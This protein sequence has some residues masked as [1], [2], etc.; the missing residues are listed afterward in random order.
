MSITITTGGITMTGAGVTFT[1][2]PP[3][4]AT[5]GWFGGGYTPSTVSTVSRI[6]FATDTATAS[7]RGSLSLARRA[8][9]ATGNT[10]D[11]WF[12]AGYTGLSPTAW[13]SLV[14]R[15]TYSTD[16]ATATVR[17]PMNLAIYGQG[18]IGTTEYGWFT[19]GYINAT[20]SANAPRSYVNRITY[21]TDTDTSSGRGPL[22]VSQ[23][24]AFNVTDST[25]YGWVAG[26]FVVATT[27][28]TVSRIIYATDTA[29][30]TTRGPLNGSFGQASG[31]ASSTNSYGWAVSGGFGT[32]SN[33][34]T[35]STIQR[36]TFATDTAT[37]SV[38]G[39]LPTYGYGSSGVGD[40]TYGWYGGFTGPFRSTV[41]RLTYATDTASATARGPLYASQ[42]S[43][44]ATSGIQ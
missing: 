23:S 30:A 39:N 15:I 9:A 21:A 8:L 41:Q 4:E 25:T 5:A 14:D 44:G 26:G 37:A 19:G 2:S 10:T 34:P 12:S 3:S 29:T 13:T 6:T 24:G 7:V 1:A 43:T 18:A 38:R 32:G 22:A 31:G 27:I 28:S 11:G 40:T 42:A 36:I 16:T 20:P 33:T 17:G 35:V